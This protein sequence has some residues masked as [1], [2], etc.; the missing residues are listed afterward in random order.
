VQGFKYDSAALLLPFM[1]AINPTILLIT[2]AT[3]LEMVWAVITAAIGM[4]TFASFIQNYMFTPYSI[5]ER[6]AAVA[7]ALLFIQSDFVT[8]GI[9]IGLFVLLVLFQL[10]KRRKNKRAPQTA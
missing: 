10:Y 4:A 1:F 6:I 7:T 8:D 5:I 2:D 9:A 3:A